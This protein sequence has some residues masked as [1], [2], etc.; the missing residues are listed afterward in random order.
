MVY[1]VA[2]KDTD[3]STLKVE[4]FRTQ[5]QVKAARR[6]WVTKHPRGYSRDH[7]TRGGHTRVISA[8]T[9]RDKEGLLNLLNS[10][11]FLYGPPYGNQ[12]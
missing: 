10:I 2:F 3:G 4:A 7:I 6:S 12:N 9:P 5:R 11:L 8:D 1:I